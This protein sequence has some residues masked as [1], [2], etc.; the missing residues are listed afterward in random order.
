L[1]LSLHENNPVE[2]QMQID[3]PA[4]CLGGGIYDQRIEAMRLFGFG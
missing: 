3:K 4:F 2:G 1:G